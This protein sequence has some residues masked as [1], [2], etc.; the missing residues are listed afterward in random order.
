MYFIPFATLASVPVS[1]PVAVK[2]A[3]GVVSLLFA[4]AAV[5]VIVAFAVGVPETVICVKL[6][7][8]TEIPL[9]AATL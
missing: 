2:V 9:T 6:L 8:V 3:L 5:S 4:V 7:R 1:A